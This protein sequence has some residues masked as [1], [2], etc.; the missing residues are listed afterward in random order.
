MEYVVAGCAAFALMGFFDLASLKRIPYLKQVIG[1]AGSLSLGYSLVRAGVFGGKLSI[2]A[3]L[4][5]AGWPLLI[6]SLFLLI[7]SLFLEIPFRRTYASNG[8]G[9]K[10]VTTGTYALVRHPGVLWFGLFLAGLL[11]VS[12]S[13]L[14]LVAAPVWLT[15]DVLYAWLQDRFLF[16]RMFPGY[17]EYRQG[18]PM[19]IPTRRSI[20]RCWRSIGYF[21]DR[22]DRQERAS[23]DGVQKLAPT[24]EG[25]STMSEIRPC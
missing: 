9:E 10:L 18:T 19:L 2:P 21:R 16:E 5:Y 23:R 13:R 17:A 14:L 6:P 12:R 25:A 15:A 4:S 7:Y 11:L 8:V 1:L 24:I 3:W 22:T 20:L